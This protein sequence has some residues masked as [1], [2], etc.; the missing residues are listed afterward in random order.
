MARGLR[1]GF[2][3]P[4]R[5]GTT[6]GPWS[7]VGR[8]VGLLWFG[9]ERCVSGSSSSAAGGWGRAAGAGVTFGRRPW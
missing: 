5:P 1:T 3:P 8:A 6:G 7:G 9:M 2:V 4:G